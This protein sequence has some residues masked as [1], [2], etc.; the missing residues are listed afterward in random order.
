MI[1]VYLPFITAIALSGIAGFYSVIGLAQIF[2]GSFLP[3]IIMGSVLEIAKLV[4]ISWLYNNWNETNRLLKSYFLLS[5]FLLM[6]ITSMGIFGFLSRAYID[7]N[8]VVGANNVQL[9][10]LNTQEKIAKD[11]LDYLLKRAGDPTTASNKIDRDI[12]NAQNELKKISEKKLPLLTE[13]NKLTAEIGPIKYVAELLYDK[14]DSNFI[15]KAVRIVILI[16]IV[17]FD[18]LAVLLLIASQQALKNFKAIKKPKKKRLDK[19][20]QNSVQLNM[21]ENE[22]IPKK[23]I[24][25]LEGA[26]LN[27]PSKQKTRFEQL[28]K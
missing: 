11:R 4:T 16:I 20:H 7:S 23:Q 3:V 6:L 21:E 26:F 15:D 13:E 25:N 18:P 14:S 1:Q 10:T 17:V 28:F 2:H 12:Q 24:T 5:I 9:Q 22:L 8:I 19:E 27:D